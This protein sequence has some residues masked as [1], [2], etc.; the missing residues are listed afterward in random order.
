[1]KFSGFIVINFGRIFL[2]FHIDKKIIRRIYISIKANDKLSE[3]NVHEHTAGMS[4]LNFDFDTLLPLFFILDQ[5]SNAKKKYR[6][7]QLRWCVGKYYYIM[8]HFIS[9]NKIKKKTNSFDL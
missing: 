9:V 1:M 7:S 2:G 8:L 5:P 4:C 6:I 3:R